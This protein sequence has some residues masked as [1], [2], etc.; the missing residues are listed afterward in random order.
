[1][2]L[3]WV[4]L[5]W[6]PKEHDP[7]SWRPPLTGKKKL[8]VFIIDA[9]HLISLRFQN[10]QHALCPRA[11]PPVFSPST[12]PQ[13]PASFLPLCSLK[14][15]RKGTLQTTVTCWPRNR[16]SSDGPASQG[17]WHVLRPLFRCSA[18]SRW[19][20][21]ESACLLGCVFVT[22]ILGHWSWLINICWTH[23]QKHEAVHLPPN[24]VKR[25][26][27]VPWSPEYVNHK[28]SFSSQADSPC[29]CWEHA[30]QSW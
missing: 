21:S 4:S 24:M 22:Q 30:S 18:V 14:L 7:Y 13:L 25:L 15:K 8:P 27:W 28:D 1:M 12:S 5:T 9:E 29:I 16:L 19:A 23:E 11:C 2:L 3:S 26:H 6:N 20:R 17:W 10:T